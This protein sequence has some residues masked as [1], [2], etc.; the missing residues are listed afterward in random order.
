MQL[1]INS[2]RQHFPDKIF[3]PTFPRFFC[4]KIPDIS[5]TA[6]KFPDTSR[7]FRQVVTLTNTT[8]V[9]PHL[10]NVSTL[11]CKIKCSLFMPHQKCIKCKKTSC[12]LQ[13][14]PDLNVVN[15][16][17]WKILQYRN[18]AEDVSNMHHWSRL[19]WNVWTL[20]CSKLCCMKQRQQ[21]IYQRHHHLSVFVKAVGE[22]FEH[23]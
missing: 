14:S 15:Y 21:A 8:N 18:I 7:F 3:S 13:N 6:V 10:I 12:S 11:P 22:H 16:S 19:T 2:F 20:K 5:L 23:H 1:T 4:S 9:H 17:M